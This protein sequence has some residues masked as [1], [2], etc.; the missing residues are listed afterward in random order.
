MTK[1]EFAEQV[2]EA[3]RQHD[4]ELAADPR[5]VCVQGRAAL[6]EVTWEQ[7]QAIAEQFAE[8]IRY[9]LAIDEIRRRTEPGL[10]ALI[11][12]RFDQTGMYSAA[13]D[14][15][16]DLVITTGTKLAECDVFA[17]RLRDAIERLGLHRNSDES[18][19]EFPNDLKK[20]LAQQDITLESPWIVGSGHGIYVRTKSKAGP[21]VHLNFTEAEVI[22]TVYWSEGD[23]QRYDQTGISYTH[24]DFAA[25][26]VEK[27][28][29]QG[30]TLPA[31]WNS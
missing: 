28:A 15:L 30:I 2:A 3:I 1:S 25:A 13:V 27:L 19:D 29:E 7:T 31:T 24:P 5:E 23:R 10:R 17:R 4:P 6:L 8:A 14:A 16:T 11:G 22:V 26:V 21:G 18:G 20:K 9:G 12:Q